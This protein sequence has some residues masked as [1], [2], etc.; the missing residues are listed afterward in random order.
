VVAPAGIDAAARLGMLADGLREAGAA[1]ATRAHMDVWP[2]FSGFTLKPLHGDLEA[3]ANDLRVT[4]ELVAGRGELPGPISDVLGGVQQLEELARGG[5]KQKRSALQQLARDSVTLADRIDAALPADAIDTTALSAARQELFSALQ[6]GAADIGSRRARELTALLPPAISGRYARDYLGVTTNVHAREFVHTL[7]KMARVEASTAERER[8]GMIELLGRGTPEAVERLR[9]IMLDLVS[10]DAKDLK[11]QAWRRIAAL[12][13][14]DSTGAILDGPRALGGSARSF[15]DVARR[16]G[17]QL[18][19]E[20]KLGKVTRRYLAAWRATLAAHTGVDGQPLRAA[21]TDPNA[22]RIFQLRE[23]DPLQLVEDLGKVGSGSF[24]EITK[25]LDFVQGRLVTLR[26]RLPREFASTMDD[27]QALAVKNLGRLGG[28]VGGG[29]GAH[30]DYAELGR[31]RSNMRLLEQ[32]LEERT[33]AAAGEQAPAAI[34]D[35]SEVIR[36]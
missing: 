19:P 21:G 20:N 34:V 18:H 25:A 8:L 29:Y 9:G 13:E 5:A 6:D 31:I 12:L 14:L 10:V 36:W 3:F 7:Q 1:Y 22:E 4:R 17:N 24:A 16:L 30:P 33:A 27:T 15:E 28:S 2:I 23:P 26:T 11:P 35:P 32:V